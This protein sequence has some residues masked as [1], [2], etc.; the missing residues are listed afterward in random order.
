MVLP[1]AF[2]PI[3]NR[4]FCIATSYWLT[5]IPQEHLFHVLDSS[6][7]EDIAFTKAVPLRVSPSPYERKCRFALRTEFDRC[8]TDRSSWLPLGHRENACWPCRLPRLSSSPAGYP[9]TPRYAPYTTVCTVCRGMYLTPRY[10]PQH[11][12][13]RLSHPSLPS[14][15][16]LR[17]PVTLRGGLCGGRQ[18]HCASLEASLSPVRAASV[19]R[20]RPS[21]QHAANYGGDD[22]CLCIEMPGS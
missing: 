2:T 15:P 18:V 4:D 3:V 13:G 16:Y 8:R 22:V 7:F 17:A 11:P 6:G 14:G 12:P 10:V 9:C 20:L 21:E 19:R 5:D 1:A